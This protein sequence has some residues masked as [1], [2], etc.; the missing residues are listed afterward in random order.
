LT[1]N[2]GISNSLK[3]ISAEHGLSSL[4]GGGGYQLL[5]VLFFAFMAFTLYRVATKEQHV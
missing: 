5:G 4:F 2:E 1:V 3:S